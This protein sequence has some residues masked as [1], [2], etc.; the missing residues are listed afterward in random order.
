[1]SQRRIRKRQTT[2]LSPY[3]LES[4]SCLLLQCTTLLFGFFTDPRSGEFRSPAM[5]APVFVVFVL[6][7][8]GVS[9]VEFTLRKGVHRLR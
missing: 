9:Y 5:V 2:L 1:M 3:R 6:I 8:A 7:V 4:N